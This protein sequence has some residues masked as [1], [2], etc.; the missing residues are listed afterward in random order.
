MHCLYFSP[1]T[2]QRVC[3]QAGFLTVELIPIQRYDL[4]NHLVWLQHGKPGGMRHYAQVFPP[5]LEAAYASCLKD[6][7]LCDTIFG[8]FQRT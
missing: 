4:S 8:I 5:A 6:R 3:R 7:W 1:D 2:L